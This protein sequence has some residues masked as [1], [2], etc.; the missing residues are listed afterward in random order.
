MVTSIME[1]N[2]DFIWRDKKRT[3]FG[4]P[5]SF[6]TYTITNDKLIIESGFLSKK[7]EEIRLYRILDITLNKPLGQRIFGVGTIHCCTADKSTPEIDIVKIKDASRIKNMLS[8]MI[9]I[10]RDAKR[11][12][13]REFINDA[14]DGHND[15]F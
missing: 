4:L 3:F 6:T 14:D 11:I 7:E 2:T 13:A 15:I 9:E 1:N 5:L 12:T 10:Q 8:D